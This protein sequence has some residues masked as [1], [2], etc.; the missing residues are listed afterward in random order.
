MCV[1]GRV[2]EPFSWNYLLGLEPDTDYRVR[3]LAGNAAGYPEYDANKELWIEYR[4]PRA[5]P[6][7]N[8][9]CFSILQI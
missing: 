9:E 4:T 2:S 5:L 6:K 8:L 7:G 1:L 3:V